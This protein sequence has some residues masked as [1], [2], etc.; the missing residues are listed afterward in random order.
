MHG[1]GRDVQTRLACMDGTEIPHLF[2]DDLIEDGGA[3]RIC[4]GRICLGSTSLRGHDD[5]GSTDL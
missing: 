2:A 1:R 4:E 3:I 5:S